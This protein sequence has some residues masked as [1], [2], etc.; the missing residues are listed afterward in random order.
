MEK[1]KFTALIICFASFLTWGM[2][3]IYW[4]Q[5]KNVHPVE[6]VAHRAIWSVL[7][8]GILVIILRQGL[9]VIK[10]LKNPKILI[11]LVCSSCL[12]AINWCLYIW[13]V[14]QNH[15]VE[16]SMGYYI[17]PLFNVAAS[18]L[19][20]KVPLNRFQYIAIG[21]A[22]LGVLNMIIGYGD[23][24]Y[25]A[26]ILAASFCIYGVIRKIT[27]VDAIAGLFIETLIIAIPSL[28]FI[29]YKTINGT[30]ALFT[31]D[32][33]TVS[34]LILGGIVTT[35]PL[36]G[37]SYAAKNMNLSTVGI[38]QYISPTTSFF[39]GVFMYD[40]VF[41]TSHLITFIFIWIG[42]IIYSTDSIIRYEIEKKHKKS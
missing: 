11:A 40:E 37:F 18:A 17:N 22:L 1:N 26:I 35:L 41:T 31:T 19:F 42:L 9:H 28:I 24:P 32:G 16:T 6:V 7:F 36:A 29:L 12:I 2:L 38:M 27:P 25:V 34:L 5:L 23:I 14:S 8:A 13:A 33:L 4:H 10:S 30:G 39:I 20:F 3:A 21:F 15:I